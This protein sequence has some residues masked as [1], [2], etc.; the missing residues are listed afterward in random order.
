MP[1][2]AFFYKSGNLERRENIVVFSK[3]AASLTLNQFVMFLLF[4][5]YIKKAITCREWPNDKMDS[6]TRISE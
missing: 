5:R 2:R 6:N 4:K 1:Q 3:T